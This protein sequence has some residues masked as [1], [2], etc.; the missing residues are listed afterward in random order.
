[1]ED[2]E[3]KQ[4]IEL[5]TNDLKHCKTQAEREAM[6]DKH[7]RVGKLIYQNEWEELKLEDFT[8]KQR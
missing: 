7:N 4:V 2:A 1:M 5:V 8:W 3:K 6:I